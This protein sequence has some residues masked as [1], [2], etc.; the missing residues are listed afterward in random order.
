MHPV[1]VL[2]RGRRETVR[3]RRDWGADP[4]G[5]PPSDEPTVTQVVL[6]LPDPAAGGT[7]LAAVAGAGGDARL[8]PEA[9]RAVRALLAAPPMP[10]SGVAPPVR[11]VALLGLLK[12]FDAELV[13]ALLPRLADGALREAARHVPREDSRKAPVRRDVVTALEAALPGFP[14]GRLEDV[15]A[16]VA[17]GKAGR[18]RC[19][20]AD[21]AV[22]LMLFG[23]TFVVGGF[24]AE[25]ALR[26]DPWNE[27]DVLAAA[28]DL[29]EVAD[30]RRDLE[31]GRGADAAALTR[32]ERATV[33]LLGR[34]GRL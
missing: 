24:K 5:R 7:A 34:L 26:V 17:A 20:P 28:K 14:T 9:E 6:R 10:A 21:V 11:T 32:L 2:A 33:A 27:T 12:T 1:Q 15:L 8:S 29:L 3:P 4:A 31:G 16:D 22:L 13:R 19:V 30:V 18:K 23:R 25:R